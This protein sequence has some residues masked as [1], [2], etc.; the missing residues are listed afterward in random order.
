[1]WEDD[2]WVERFLRLM[3]PTDGQALFEGKN[4]FQLSSK[5]LR[6]ARRHMQIIF[7]DPYSSLNP[8]MTVGHDRGRTAHHSWACQRTRPSGAGVT[9]FGSSRA[10]VQNIMHGIP[11]SFLAGQRQRVGI[12][13][14][15]ALRPKFIVCDEAVS[16]LDV[17]IQAQIINL[18]KRSCNK[19]FNSPIYSLP[20]ILN[21]VEYLGSA[22]SGD[23]PWKIG[24]NCSGRDIIS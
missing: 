5:E 21:V 16:A 9:A 6:R 15:L 24:R 14:A 12:A 11:M 20:M 22:D 17:S 13:R 23:V 8:R 19:N 4:I 18:F 2:S 10:C 1:M 3:E 7:Q